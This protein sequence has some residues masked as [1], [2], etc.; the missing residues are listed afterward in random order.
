MTHW[1]VFIST[2]FTGSSW[3]TVDA[4]CAAIFAAHG[5]RVRLEMPEETSQ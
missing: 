1:Y 5:L 3:V 2:S 4:R